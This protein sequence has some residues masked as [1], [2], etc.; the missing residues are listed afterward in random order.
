MLTT[1][2]LRQQL[3]D[4]ETQWAGVSHDVSNLLAAI[5]GHSE[6]LLAQMPADDKLR[7]MLE[8]ILNAGELAACWM[9]Q[10]AFRSQ[11]ERTAASRA[12][13]KQVV[14]G[15]ESTLRLLTGETIRLHLEYAAEAIPVLAEPADVGRILLNLVVNARDALSDGGDLTIRAEI[16]QEEA[17][18]ENGAAPPKTYGRISVSDTGEGISR[19]DGRRV[20]DSFYSTKGHHRGLGLPTARALA[21]RN[22]GFIQ[23]ESKPHSGTT[24]YTWFPSALEAPKNPETESF[25]QYPSGQAKRIL[26]VEDDPTLRAILIRTLE[27]AGYSVLEAGDGVQALARYEKQTEP[28]DLLLTD[29]RMARM[30]GREVGEALQAR[31]PRLKIIYISGYPDDV[32]PGRKGTN[33]FLKPFKPTALVQKVRETLEGSL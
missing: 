22:G 11:A 4:T 5:L 12:D 6:L 2:K 9:K 16:A 30:N 31:Q 26:V 28:I 19:E 33:L 18:R 3:T 20:F 15:M 24:F 1:R 29:I 27:S 21:E 13:L 10:S 7:P 25:R 23:F 8:G 32:V 14:Q 17:S